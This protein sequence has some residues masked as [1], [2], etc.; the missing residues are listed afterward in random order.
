M[1]RVIEVRAER[2]VAGGLALCRDD[3]GRIVLVE[4][5]LPGELVAAATREHRGTAHGAVRAII[6]PAPGRVEPPCPYVALGCGGCDWQHASLALQAAM[7]AEIVS[8]ALR[9]LGHLADPVVRSG[10]AVSAERAR[11]SLR[12]AVDGTRLGLRHPGSHDVVAVADC[13]VALPSLTELLAPGVVD[14]GEAVEMT[15]RVATTGERMIIAEPTAIGVRAP[16]DVTVI[17]GNE[18]ANGRR[19]WFHT[20]IAGV[21]LRVSARSFLQ[22]RTEGAEVL[23][24]LVKEQIADAPTGALVDLYGGI[25]LFAATVAGDRPVVVVESS[26][27]AAADA[28]RN[29]ADRPARVIDRPVDRWRPSPAAVVVADPARAG[30]GAVGVAKIRETGAARVVLISCDAASLGRD[31]AGLGRAG[32]EHVESVVVD[33]FGHTGHVEVVSRFDGQAGPTSVGAHHHYARGASPD[34]AQEPHRR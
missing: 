27:S 5:A 18:L 4:G 11:N 3:E 9:R 19:C 24:A 25:G 28:R 32:Y 33:M 10:P 30:L 15:I 1:D 29:L 8:D 12:L 2:M 23:V 34:T 22:V 6:E 20:E 17:G 13:L 21:R 14:P 31:A 7:R 26:K 16:E